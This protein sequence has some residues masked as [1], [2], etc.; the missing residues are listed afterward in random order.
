M[1]FAVH[2][3]GSPA[4]SPRSHR[5]PCG[6]VPGR[7]HVSVQRVSAG[8]AA[9]QGLALAA[10][11]CGVPAGRAPLARIRG[12]YLLHSAGGLVLQA[13]DHQAPSLGKDAPVQSRFLSDIPPRFN[14]GPSCRAGHVP[15]PQILDADHVEPLSDVCRYLLAPV[16]AD[17][18]AARLELGGSMP[19]PRAAFRA[20]LSLRQF[21]LKPTQ[22][23]LLR[24]GQA[25]TVQQPSS[26]QSC[27][28]SHTP[29]NADNLSRSRHLDGLWD[30][31]ERH[32]PAPSPVSGHSVRFHVLR[33]LSG[34][35]E[36]HPPS[37]GY[38]DLPCVAVQP[39]YVF[40]LDVDY[41]EPLI[42]IGL[43]PRRAAMASGE[44]VRHR[45]VM[46][47]DRLLLHDHAARGQPWV[48]RPCLR[49]LAAAF[50][51]SRHAPAS[52]SP[53]RL[54]LNAQVPHVPSVRAVSQER[55]FL[56]RRQHQPVP[57][58]ADN[59]AV[60]YDILPRC[61]GYSMPSRPEGQTTHR[62]YW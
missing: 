54:L 44:E 34:P 25:R 19:D 51:E 23:S 32:M 21:S 13:A 22:P 8:H 30:D 11:H 36:P 60:G 14:D 50:R 62:R 49:Q 1:R 33:Y 53:V 59:V 47:A 12:T 38:P 29:V 24:G 56:G 42:P 57:G 27:A 39:P 18:C 4:A 43:S 48:L 37:L 10:A 41:A 46:V 26:G 3:P 55:C 5:M 16:F 2:R 35:A 28:D 31:G 61:A 45:L 40:R 15:D 6:D 9:E 17:V 52:R 58:H 7:V 20:A